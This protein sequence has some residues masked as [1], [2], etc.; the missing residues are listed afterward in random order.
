MP[1]TKFYSQCTILNCSFPGH[2]NNYPDAYSITC[3]QLMFYQLQP[4]I[5]GFLFFFSAS[6]EIFKID[7]AKRAVY[8][9]GVRFGLFACVNKMDYV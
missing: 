4:E 6:F 5:C 9:V 3:T 2:L 7:I 8:F 1:Q